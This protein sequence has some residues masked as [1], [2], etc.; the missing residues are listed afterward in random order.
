MRTCCSQKR[1][2]S[3]VE[4][5]LTIAI[6]PGEIKG[7]V[8]GKKRCIQLTWHCFLVKVT[9]DMGSRSPGYPAV[10]LSLTDPDIRSVI[11]SSL[12]KTW[13]GP[14][15]DVIA[16]HQQTFFENSI[17]CETKQM[18]RSRQRIFKSLASR[19]RH[20]RNET[21]RSKKNIFSRTSAERATVVDR[22]VRRYRKDPETI[23]KRLDQKFLS[24]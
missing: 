6:L 4:D 5:K 1:N 10:F 8:W 17:I 16:R 15:S 2:T 12:G 18:G 23:Q 11:R 3:G 22:N 9:K 7:T 14:S 13:S 20:K 24:E 19:R 21:Q